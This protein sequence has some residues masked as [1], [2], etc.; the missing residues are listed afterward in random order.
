MTIARVAADLGYERL[1]PEQDLQVGKSVS[2]AYKE[3]YGHWPKKHRQEVRGGC[4][5]LVYT[6]ARSDRYLVERALA[7]LQMPRAA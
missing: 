5:A 4:I 2:K 3:I 7:E 6:Y 1:T